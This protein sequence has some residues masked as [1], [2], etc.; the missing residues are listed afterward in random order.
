MLSFTF[1]GEITNFKINLNKSE[2]LNIFRMADE[3][4]RLKPVLPFSCRTKLLKYLGIFLTPK[5]SGLSKSNY[6]PLLNTI[7][8]D[9]H[10]WSHLIPFMVRKNKHYKNE[11]FF[12]STVL[13][14]NAALWCTRFLLSTTLFDYQVDVEQGY[15]KTLLVCPYSNK[16]EWWFGTARFSK[17]LSSCG[18]E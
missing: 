2:I 11:Y 18:V 12:Q 17:K 9:L 8:Q 4:H 5:L 16:K 15:F 3:V 6:M 14:S 13:F 7:K 1:Y 10:R